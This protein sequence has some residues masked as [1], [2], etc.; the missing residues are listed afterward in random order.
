MTEN[1]TFDQIMNSITS[2]LIG[3]QQ[4]DRL[5]LME[6]A[7]KYKNHEFGT[8]ILRAC[9]RLIWE[10]LPE[11]AR[12]ELSDIVENH[13]A[14]RDS[15]Y[16]EILFN[17]QGGNA[18]RA[19]DL[20][21]PLVK[22]FDRDIAAGVD[23]SDSVSEKLDFADIRE[24]T[25]YLMA[26]D[27]KK[28][29]R[30]TM[31]NYARAYGQYGVILYEL[32]R[33]EEAVAALEKAMKWNPASAAIPFEIGENLKALGDMDGF[34]SY[35]DRAYPIIFKACDIAKYHRNK[36][37][38]GIE[39]GDFE[40]AAA[41]FLASTLF[42]DSPLAMSEL[43]YMKQQ[44]GEDFTGME[45]GEALRVLYGR[46]VPVMISQRAMAANQSALEHAAAKEEWP[47]V[48]D[49]LYDIWKTT[50]NEEAKEMLDELIGGKVE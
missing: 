22:E 25:M 27:P 20:I 38:Y 5:Y 1:K 3:D 9:G 24:Y 17:L 7:E 15:V 16:Q 21:E 31:E 35:S 49:I 10:C 12:Q 11:D 41:H 13:H 6:Q 29:I 46:D 23:A 2:G 18:R 48:A 37:F 39:F 32:G 30:P 44:C 36:G 4:K 14:G 33:H 45:V 19:C 43:M 42:E 34:I 26:F 28:D 50:M 47:M 40:G 8:E